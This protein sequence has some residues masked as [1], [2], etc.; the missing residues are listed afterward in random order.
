MFCSRSLPP[1]T[2]R[3]VKLTGLV[4]LFLFFFHFLQRSDIPLDKGWHPE[5]AQ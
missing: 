5:D 3:T 2:Q 4:F 1:G